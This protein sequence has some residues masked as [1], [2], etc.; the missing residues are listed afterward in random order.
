MLRSRRLPPAGV[1]CL[2]LY[3]TAAVGEEPKSTVQVHI[4]FG[5]GFE[6]R[7]TALA[8]EEGMTVLDA[9]QAAARHPHGIRFAH[10]GEGKTA[11]LSAI[12]DVANEGA[13]RNW[14]YHVN[15]DRGDRS[16][17]VKTLSINDVVRWKFGPD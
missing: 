14:I 11:F 12:D 2:L 5:D 16:I 8:W 13:E 4:D 17:G 6:K 15:Q 10:S 7:Y 9:M 3:C 1:L